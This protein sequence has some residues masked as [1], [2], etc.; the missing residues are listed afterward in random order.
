MSTKFSLYESNPDVDKYVNEGLVSINQFVENI[1]KDHHLKGAEI[2][3]QAYLD[4]KP[5]IRS[6][7][8][9]LR[10][11]NQLSA[12][13]KT[14]ESKSEIE[15]DNFELRHSENVIG[16]SQ[17]IAET[18]DKFNYL[19]KQISEVSSKI[20]PLGV[21]MD[22]ISSSRDK[23]QEII[24]LIRAYHGFYT[25]GEYPHLD[26]L[27]ISAKVED[28]VKCA[29]S[30]KELM[31]LASRISDEALPKTLK[32]L[33]DIEAYGKNMENE[34]LHNF[35]TLLQGDESTDGNVDIKRM[36]TIATVLFVYNDG[37]NLIETFVSKNAINN[38]LDEGIFD[39]VGVTSSDTQELES[40]LR[41]FYLNVKFEIKS[42]ARISKKIF[43][44]PDMV[45]IMVVQR[46]YDGVIKDQVSR[47][48]ARAREV[49][50]L[51]YLKTIGVL[52]KVIFEFTHEIKDYLVTED[53]NKDGN[54]L[55][56]MDQAYTHLFLEFIRDDV[57]L[58]EEYRNIEETIDSTL[59]RFDPVAF[60]YQSKYETINTAPSSEDEHIA[61]ANERK[62]LAQF[63]QY[64][65]T[66][67]GEKR[68]DE[69][70]ISKLELE[71]DELAA[72]EVIETLIKTVAE[73]IGRMLEV[74]PL[75]VPEHAVSAL[76]ILISNFDKLSVREEVQLQSLDFFL[77]LYSI[78]FKKELLFC[79]STSAKKIIFPCLGSLPVA[80]SKAKT[81][82][83]DFVKRHEEGIN[84]LLKKTIE[85]SLTQIQGLLNKQKKKDFVCDKI[86]EDTEA[87]ELVSGFLEE[88]YAN[89]SMALSG[90]NLETFLVAIGHGLLQQLLEHYKKF[91]VNS[92]GG[93]VL[94]RDVI[95]YQSRVDEWNIPLLSE[96]F[97]I[98]KEIGNLFT[99]QSDLVNSLVT[100]GQLSQMKPYTVRQYIS[101][102]TDFNPSYADR[103]FKFR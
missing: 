91:A 80:K 96:K 10:E 11:L 99:V 25:K 59:R 76:T 60:S 70:G 55:A 15:V 85:Y 51:C 7:E 3:K 68:Q 81:L 93:V 45:L 54:L 49:G 33:K 5:Y 22:K 56:A 40:K 8:S 44:D 13:A 57:L 73:S 98:L 79:L 74:L 90:S 32:C 27:K 4:P 67:I 36:N 75:R 65:K 103:F 102:R 52:K 38:S 9:N 94:T 26:T 19:D 92:I 16:L 39:N 34:L 64:V 66:K 63:K 71:E 47:V 62:K 29:K 50:T 77:S 88:M 20:N 30:V 18:T 17:Q 97:Q 43:N 23:S 2:N 84:L 46:L 1:S 6:F 100:E 12:D 101:K 69:R 21:T 42:K 35:E 14:Q 58:T 41:E 48:L 78:Q 31:K 89:V 87:C 37:V 95:Q 24:F 53:F 82:I 61:F 83:N 28:N 86:E 72:I